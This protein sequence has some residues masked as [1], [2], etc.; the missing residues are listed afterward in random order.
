MKIWSSLLLTY[1]H[2]DSIEIYFAF[3]WASFYFLGILE[4]YSF[5]WKF[6]KKMKIRKW[7]HSTGP[8]IRPKALAQRG[9]LAGQPMHAAPHGHAHSR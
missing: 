4:V 9:K 6:K 3:F 1:T 5:F 2:K 7:E 8:R